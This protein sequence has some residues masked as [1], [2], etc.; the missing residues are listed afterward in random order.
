MKHEASSWRCSGWAQG[1]QKWKVRQGVYCQLGKGLARHQSFTLRATFFFFSL[2]VWA[3]DQPLHASSKERMESGRRCK[4]GTR[5]A[6]GLPSMGISGMCFNPNSACATSFFLFNLSLLWK[7]RRTWLF[8][9]REMR[10]AHRQPPNFCSGNAHESQRL[11][12]LEAL[13]QRHQQGLHPKLKVAR[14][15]DPQQ[16]KEKLQRWASQSA[17][18]SS[19]SWAAQHPATRPGPQTLLYLG[20]AY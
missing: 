16:A 2:Q 7:E 18:A 8:R 13:V 9:T 10:L 3:P 17:K 1:C 14:R 11:Q 12:A 19:A 15:P 20:S 4:A 6:V 5:G